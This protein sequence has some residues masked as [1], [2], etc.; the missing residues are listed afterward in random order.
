MKRLLLICMAVAFGAAAHAQDE[1][2]S[3]TAERA[4]L[5]QERQKADAVYKAE[6]K[7]CYGKFA[8]NDCLDSAKA[9]RREIVSDLRRQEVALNDAQRKRAAAQRR[10]EIDE[11]NAQQRERAASA[12]ARAASQADRGARGDERAATRAA[13]AASAPSMAAQREQQVRRR[14][15]EQEAARQRRNEDAARK[16][17]EHDARLADA[18]ARAEKMKKREAE[19]KKPAASAL[20]DP[21]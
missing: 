9:R 1:D 4:R 19:R 10:S 14:V 13:Q 21:R 16:A 6:E 8:V 18:A 20:Q 5:K 7:A 3:I 2:A 17:R 12:P 15:A 11:K